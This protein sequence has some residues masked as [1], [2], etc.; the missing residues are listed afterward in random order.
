MANL[1]ELDRR[2]YSIYNIIGRLDER[3]KYVEQR[4][5]RTRAI[6]LWLLGILASGTVTLI[7]QLLTT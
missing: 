1:E 3:L 4:E 2:V 5:K 6:L 7:I